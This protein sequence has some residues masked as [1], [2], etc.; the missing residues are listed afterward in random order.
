MSACS[1]PPRN[2]ICP[3]RRFSLVLILQQAPTRGA[4]L[5]ALVAAQLAPGIVQLALQA[6]PAGGA[7]RPQVEP[8]GGGGAG[9]RG[10]PGVRLGAAGGRS[11]VGVTGCA[12]SWC[13]AQGTHMHG[14]ASAAGHNLPRR[15]AAEAAAPTGPAG[16]AGAAPHARCRRRPARG[17]RPPLRRGGRAAQADEQIV[18][19]H[20][21]HVEGIQRR[22]ER[23]V[24]GRAAGG[25][26]FQKADAE[27]NTKRNVVHLDASGHSTSEAC[28]ARLLQ[29]APHRCRSG[30]TTPAARRWSARP[31]PPQSALC[32][33]WL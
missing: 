32:S 19:A 15:S 16:S 13:R 20:G 28:T 17:K 5:L 12:S 3:V 30:C 1:P 18:S 33:R 6:L 21:R 25:S 9:V 7:Q 29:K 14:R 22:R 2:P 24:D 23:G 10:Q 27:H 11:G 8:G 31:A 4:Q 26:I